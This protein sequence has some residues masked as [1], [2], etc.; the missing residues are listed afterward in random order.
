M[1]YQN[2]Y[3]FSPDFIKT[4]L[5]NIYAAGIHRERYGRK[6]KKALSEL[7]NSQYFSQQQIEDY[8][9]VQLSLLVHHAYESVP[10][11]KKLFD[12]LSLKSIDLF[13]FQ[14]TPLFR[15]RLFLF[16]GFIPS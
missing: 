12:D 6:F 7:L 13:S 2:I 10:Y 8:Q 11:Y 14:R 9:C 5:L 16:R 3:N 15:P 1:D 4:F